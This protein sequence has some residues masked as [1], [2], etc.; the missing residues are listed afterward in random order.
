MA[1]V[2]PHIPLLPSNLGHIG[3]KAYLNQTHSAIE[4]LELAY[5]F[6]RPSKAVAEIWTT[7]SEGGVDHFWGAN[8]DPKIPS[9]FDAL[10]S[11]RS[12]SLL[13]ES[14]SYQVK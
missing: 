12:R 13:V 7:A 6:S 14:K 4:K 1:V 3:E 5:A 2:S 8:L 11:P 10:P 9:Q